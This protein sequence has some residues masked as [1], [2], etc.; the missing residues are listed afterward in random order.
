MHQSCNLRRAAK[1]IMPH[2]QGNA[3]TDDDG[4]QGSKGRN[5]NRLEKEAGIE[6]E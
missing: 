6:Y 4:L 1:Q 3:N 2:T 5:M